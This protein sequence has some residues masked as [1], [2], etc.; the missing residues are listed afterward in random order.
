MFPPKTNCTHEK[1]NRGILYFQP[2]IVNKK[3][4][5]KI[6]KLVEIAR[7]RIIIRAT[8]AQRLCMA[9]LI[10]TTYKAILYTTPYTLFLQR[11]GKHSKN[12]KIYI[13][14][15][16][17]CRLFLPFWW[18]VRKLKRNLTC[19]S[20]HRPT[21]PRPP[22]RWCFHAEQIWPAFNLSALSQNCIIKEVAG[23]KKRKGLRDWM[24]RNRVIRRYAHMHIP[25]KNLS[26]F[27][28]INT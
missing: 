11:N 8:P 16:E 17:I 3:E 18:G 21:S 10:L 6:S 4:H 1:R 23:L 25:E 24:S 5:A 2:F 7:E 27:S 20:R 19:T 9:V 12:E 26:A 13:P 22:S 15:Y 14:M 28:A